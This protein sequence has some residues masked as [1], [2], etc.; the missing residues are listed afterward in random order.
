MAPESLVNYIRSQV[1]SGQRLDYITSILLQKGFSQQQINDAYKQLRIV[2]S[3]QAN[4][5]LI[6]IIILAVFIVVV[7]GI[8][9]FN[10]NKSFLPSSHPFIASPGSQIAQPTQSLSA[11]SL[12]TRWTSTVGTSFNAVMYLKPV[13]SDTCKYTDP[14]LGYTIHYPTNWYVHVSPS[15]PAEENNGAAQPYTI[16][17]FDSQQLSASM[18]SPQAVSIYITPA[19]TNYSDIISYMRSIQK[20]PDQSYQ[21]TI[22]K[23]V[24]QPKNIAG[25]KAVQ[26][27][28]TLGDNVGIDTKFISKGVLYDITFNGTNLDAINANKQYYTNLLNSFTSKQAQ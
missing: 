18:T 22:E 19:K 25:Q 23:Y 24:Y 11:C 12:P 15:H 8:Y 6:T 1:S 20:G 3:S 2:K 5:L 14:L 17:S 4:H 16:I 27:Q 7:L 26:M 10:K 9:A 13:S 28:Y 21:S